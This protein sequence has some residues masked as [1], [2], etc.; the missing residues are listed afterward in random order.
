MNDSSVNDNVNE[1]VKNYY[2]E[3]LTDKD[4]LKT[5]ACCP[6]DA[7]PEHLRP[8]LKNIHPEIQQKFYGCGSP[9]PHSLEGKTVLD[10]GC[11][12]G[13][14]AYL[15]S[16]LVGERG[17]VIGIDMTEAQLAVARKYQDY[18][19]QAFGHADS[20]VEFH[21]SYIEDLSSAGIADDSLDLVISN[22][23]INLSDDKEKVFREIFRVLKPGGELYFSDVFADRRIP[24]PLQRDP[25][26]L[27]E[28]LGG[29][30][31]TEDFRRL[32]SKIGIHDFRAVSKGSIELQDPTIIN[33]A[34]MIAFSSITLRAF[35][36][37][38]EDIC[39][40]YGHVAFY[41]GGIDNSPHRF[42]LD[43]HHLFEKGLPLAVC[44]NTA[45]MLSETRYGEH[46]DVIGDFSTHYGLFD[47][48]ADGDGSDSAAPC[49]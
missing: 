7:M 21:H 1:S 22:C 33:Q 3:V 4:D 14:D 6:I 45:K 11:G 30:M 29:A 18:H 49:C 36:L 25:V 19:R 38:L 39:E 17:R 47:C 44:G 15:L 35:K 41:R 8:L 31:Y 37:A 34:G 32:L 40:N 42:M 24:Q 28:C 12:T 23:V 16:Q 5:S 2:G 48:S 46:F 26:L 20:N 27:G 43:D 10:L 13:R 9:I